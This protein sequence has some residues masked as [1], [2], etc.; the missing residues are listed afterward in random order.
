MTD[1]KG[2]FCSQLVYSER[3]SSHPCQRRA[4]VTR[5]GRPYCTQHDPVRVEA[6]A[7]ARRR[8]WDAEWEAKQARWL[9]EAALKAAEAAVVEAAMRIDLGASVLTDPS[10]LTLARAQVTLRKLRESP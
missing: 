6:A 8:V 9:K 3:V 4:K 2:E 5:D 1:K 7:G 10:L